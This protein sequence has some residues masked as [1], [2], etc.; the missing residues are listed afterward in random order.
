MHNETI[1]FGLAV[2]RS[3]KWRVYRIRTAN[4]TYELEVQTETAEGARRCAVLTCI[5]PK[6]PV[7]FEDSAPRISSEPLYALSPVDWIGK[8]L[9]VGT[10]CTSEIHS[11]DFVKTSA[12]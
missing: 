9:T 5:E 12:T 6:R 7:C 2:R 4:S 8:R 10:A 11:V 3:E 1:V